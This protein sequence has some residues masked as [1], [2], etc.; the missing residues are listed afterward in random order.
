MGTTLGEALLAIHKSY[1]G[2]LLP[3]LDTGKI[4]G[5]SHITGGGIIGNTKRI[6]PEGLT[7]HIDW[8]SWSI[9]PIY[10]IIQK[11]GTIADEEMRKAFNLGIGMIIAVSPENVDFIMNACTKDNPKIIGELR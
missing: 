8:N 3:L 5:L 9:P 7:L 2:L 11:T 6:V 10:S 4:K 1:A